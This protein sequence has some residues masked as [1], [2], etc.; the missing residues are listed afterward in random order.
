VK[1]INR[2]LEINYQ[3]R[4][5]PKFTEEMSGSIGALPLVQA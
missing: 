4:V 1:A 3:W 5:D 2:V